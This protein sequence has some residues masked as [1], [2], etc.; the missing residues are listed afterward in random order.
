[1]VGFRLP[2][3]LCVNS[4]ALPSPERR[5][6]HSGYRQR[7][8]VTQQPHADACG[9]R[10]L[11]HQFLVHDLPAEPPADQRAR[12]QCADRQHQVGR[13]EVHDVKERLVLEHRQRPERMPARP[14]MENGDAPRLFPLVSPRASTLASRQITGSVPYFPPISQSGVHNLV[15]FNLCGVSG[16]P[17]VI[18]CASIPS[19]MYNPGKTSA[20][21]LWTGRQ[22]DRR[23][24]GMHRSIPSRMLLVRRLTT[25]A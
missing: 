15:E 21:S 20:G 9:E 24:L 18:S 6:E 5:N 4:R 25:C 16:M 3:A 7:A 22:D 12:R 17:R 1:M 13:H 8:H 19:R 10:R 23:R 14:E 2:F 11:V